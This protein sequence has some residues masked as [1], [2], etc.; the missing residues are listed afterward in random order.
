MSF[1][2][3]ILSSVVFLWLTAIIHSFSLF[4][5]AQPTNET[6]KQLIEL[7]TTYHMDAGAGFRPTWMNMFKALS[8]CF[9]LVCLFGGLL[10]LY[11]WRRRVVDGLWTGILNIELVVYGIM[12]AVMAR[13]TFLP[14]IV[15]SALIFLSILIARMKVKT[16]P[17]VV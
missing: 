8:T 12:L 13:F 17:A 5:E 11:L 15:L 9:S 16:L 3:F 7:V 6:E 14:P 2:T 1:K 10:N 4:M